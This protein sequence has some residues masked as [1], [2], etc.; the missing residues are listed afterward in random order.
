MHWSGNALTPDLLAAIPEWLDTSWAVLKVIIGFSLI[1]FVHELGHFLAA[2]WVGIR[3]D[4]FAVGFGYRLFGWRRGEGFTLGSRPNY[5]GEELKQR[6]WGETDYCF[7]ALPLGGYVKMLG[8]DDI[9]INDETGEIKMSDDPRAFTN[10]PVGQRMIVVSAGVIFNIVFAVFGFMAAYMI[11]R[12]SVPAMIGLVMPGFPAEQAGLQTGDRILEADAD[13]VQTFR[14]LLLAVILSDDG[15]VNL[16]VERNGEVLPEPLLLKVDQSASNPLV[17]AGFDQPRTNRLGDVPDLLESLPGLQAG[18]RV[19]AVG[20]QPVENQAEYV[21]EFRDIAA[22]TNATEVEVTV[23][24]PDPENPEQVVQKTTK[25][26]VGLMVVGP[27]ERGE[28]A[29][30]GSGSV[31]GFKYRYKVGTIQSGQA[32]DEAGLKPEDV[33]VRWGRILHPRYDEIVSVIQAEAGEKVPVVVLRDGKEVELTVTPRRPFSLFSEQRA[34]VGVGFEPEVQRAVVADVA[35]NSPA[36]AMNIPRGARLT[37]IDGRDV[38]SWLDVVQRFWD[39]AGKQVS[40]EYEYAGRLE[41]AQMQVPSSVVDAL[42]MPRLALIKRIAGE[43]SVRLEGGRVATLPSPTAVAALLAR[44]AGERV[45]VVW[46]RFAQGAQVQTGEFQVA[47]DL[48][49]IDPWQL[50][51]DYQVPGLPFEMRHTIVRASNPFQAVALGVQSTYEVLQEVYLMIRTI[52]RN[53]FE[54][55]TSTVQHVAGPVGII[56]AA[57]NRAKVGFAEL[58]YFF[59]FLSVNLAV[60]NFLPFPVVDGGLMVFL[61]IEKIKGKPL[62]LKTQMIATMVGLATIVL[63][64]LLVTIQDIS[65]LLS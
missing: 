22:R 6:K 11:G 42:E 14:D 50:R 46:Q 65:R 38:R 58:L 41:T 32:G 64:F 40:I 35:P 9:Q 10:K 2:K 55:R 29:E 57:V 60:I 18:D 36:A 24:R 37:A 44:H 19:V 27:W 59:A 25:L 15:Q 45:E 23:E 48:S 1:I 61:I 13:P 3:V 8:Q 54:A 12:P 7:K 31:L 4:R 49:N 28:T 16:R 26:P 17:A 56:G 52:A 20:G 34:F 47:A 51:I 21:F 63:V 62:G 5:T 33:I 43:R 53:A 39:S 30:A